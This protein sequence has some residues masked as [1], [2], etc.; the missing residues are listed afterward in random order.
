MIIANTAYF[1]F[2][3]QE[4]GRRS[5]MAEWEGQDLVLDIATW[6]PLDE[7]VQ[8]ARSHGNVVELTTAVPTITAG[9]PKEA[10]HINLSRAD[11]ERLHAWLTKTLEDTSDGHA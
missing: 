7:P 6:P 2:D 8:V 1:G 9:E 11:A 5:L 4:H 3:T 10:L